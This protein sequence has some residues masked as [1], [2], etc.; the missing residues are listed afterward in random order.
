MNTVMK[1]RTK[2]EKILITFTLILLIACTYFIGLFMPA[3]QRLQRAN[4]TLDQ[5]TLRKQEVDFSLMGLADAR[6]AY[7][8][9]RAKAIDAHDDFWPFTDNNEIDRYLTNMCIQY[10]LA[11]KSL[12]ISLERL[13]IN[14]DASSSSLESVIVHV[15]VEGA[16]S[17]VVEL[18][19]SVQD[20]P[21]LRINQIDYSAARTQ[22]QPSTRIAFEIFVQRALDL[23]E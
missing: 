7:K 3:L 10:G 18:S 12:T 20:S 11:P 21:Y 6:A 19:D 16:F 23:P 15:T 1:N 2:R 13:P 8:T 22:G 4:T 9:L 14:G 5:L 17:K